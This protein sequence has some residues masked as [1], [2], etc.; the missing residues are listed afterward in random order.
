[1]PISETCAQ[2]H[3]PVRFN[4]KGSGSPSWGSHRAWWR[5]VGGTHARGVLIRSN[6]GAREST[7]VGSVGAGGKAQSNSDPRTTRTCRL[8]GSQEPPAE[9]QHTVCTGGCS[10][11]LL[12]IPHAAEAARGQHAFSKGA[13]GLPLA[14]CRVANAHLG[15]REAGRQLPVREPDH[16]LGQVALWWRQR[17]S[18]GEMPAATH[19]SRVKHIKGQPWKAAGPVGHLLT[20]LAGPCS[21]RCP[22]ACTQAARIAQRSDPLAG[23]G[24]RGHAL[25]AAHR[26]REGSRTTPQAIPCQ[27][28]SSGV[29]IEARST[30]ASSQ[31]R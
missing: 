11:I 30:G 23:S 22:R 18:V 16:H 21:S 19:A 17:P 2:R 1:M 28:I 10:R 27:G 15:I 26:H 14:T 6:S 20:H 29:Q 9:G 12:S 24:P 25:P 5:S 7:P 13:P 31:Q 4:L 3:E 8:A